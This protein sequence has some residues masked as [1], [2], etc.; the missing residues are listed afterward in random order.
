MVE[1]PCRGVTDPKKKHCYH[2]AN[3]FQVKDL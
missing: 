1:V 2:P 3:A